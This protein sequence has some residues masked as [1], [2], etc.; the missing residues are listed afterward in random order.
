MNEGDDVY[1]IGHPD[2]LHWSITDGIIS[3]IRTNYSIKKFSLKADLIQNTAPI[4][5]G[6]SGGPLL[7][8][9]GEIIGVNTIGDNTAN[10]NFAVSVKHISELL[11]SM[12]DEIEP[13]ET[14]NEELLSKKFNTVIPGDYNNNGVTD[15]WSVDT[16]DNGIID[17]VYVDDNED[18]KIEVIYIDK[19][20]NQKWD[21]IVFDDDL[22]GN[23]NRQVI[24]EDED[25]KPD[26][27]AYDF[28][29]DGEWDKFKLL[30]KDKS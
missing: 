21:M 25:G 10:F 27:I 28:N 26:V 4:L 14:I 9:K 7:N 30:E 13:I 8:E 23:P 20:E 11:N 16:N 3:N 29:Q 24:D 5:G 18:G 15:E 2:S 12:P 1:A 6:S 22:D 17:A 19:N